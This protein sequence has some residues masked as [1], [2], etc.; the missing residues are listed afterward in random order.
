[1]MMFPIIPHWGDWEHA[2]LIMMMMMTSSCSQ[3]SQCCSTL[4]R[5]KPGTATACGLH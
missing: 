2:K 1:M 5:Q 4:R 3:S